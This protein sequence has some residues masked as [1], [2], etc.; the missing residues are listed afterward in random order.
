MNDI[1]L[2]FHVTEA[3][4]ATNSRLQRSTA[5]CFLTATT[6]MMLQAARQSPSTDAR[7]PKAGRRDATRANS[8]HRKDLA[9]LFAGISDVD[10]SSFRPN[11]D[12][13]LSVF[14]VLVQLVCCYIAY[15]LF[16]F[17]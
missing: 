14:C 5:P 13:L 10:V 6:K 7:T 12:Q 16:P 17:L 11:L 8:S 15:L 2:N 1:C 3:L 9:A 4:L